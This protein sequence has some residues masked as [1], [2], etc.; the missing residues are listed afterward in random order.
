MRVENTD[1]IF[2]PGGHQYFLWSKTGEIRRDDACLDYGGT[3]VILYPC[4]GSRSGPALL[5]VYQ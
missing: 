4:H 5:L 3:E 1:Y 2:P